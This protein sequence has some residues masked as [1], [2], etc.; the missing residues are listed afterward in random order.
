M[1]SVA[2]LSRRALALAI[3]VAAL[4]YFVDIYDL[5]LFSIV[6]VRSLTEIGVPQAQIFSTGVM[7]LNMQMTGMLI[8]GIALGRARRQARPAVGAVRHDRPLLAGE[9]AE[10]GGLDR[11]SIRGSAIHRRH[12]SR[13]GAR[14]RHHPGERA[15]AASDARLCD[16]ARRGVRHPAARSRHFSSAI[17][18]SWR[19]AFVVGGLMGIALLALRVG[20]SES[21]MFEQVK[22]ESH[23]RGQFLEPVHELAPRVALHRV[24]PDRRADLVRRRDSDHVLAGVRRGDGHDARCRMPARP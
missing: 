23:E 11:A 15:D 4:G 16:L 6:R 12:R 8:G 3:T 13:R 21:G 22:A 10:R 14:R 2:P 7:L 24:D 17:V 1:P 18:S 19:A 9:P 5:I 20:V